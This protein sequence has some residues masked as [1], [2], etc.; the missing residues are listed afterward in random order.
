MRLSGIGEVAL[1]PAL[2]LG[3]RRLESA[4]AVLAPCAERSAPALQLGF[5]GAIF[6]RRFFLSAIQSG[7]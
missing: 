5:G 6:S 3:C 1:R 2:G 7:I 4:A